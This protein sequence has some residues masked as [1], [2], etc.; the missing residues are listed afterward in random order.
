MIVLTFWASLMAQTVKNLP[1][2]EE[3]L[4]QSLGREDLI[5]KGMAIHPVFLPVDPMDR[6]AWQVIVHGVAK[7]LDATKQLTHSLSSFYR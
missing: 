5:E 7:E 4:V 1:A 6:G 3:K 2:M